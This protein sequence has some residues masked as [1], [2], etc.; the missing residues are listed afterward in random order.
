MPIKFNLNISPIQ[1]P[2]RSQAANTFINNEVSVSGF[3]RI[4][5]DST[6]VSQ[7]LN[8]VTMRVIGNMECANIFGAKIVT[9]NVICARGRDG[10]DQN[11]CLGGKHFEFY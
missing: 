7:N 2:S 9:S 4:T 8:Y 10:K 11:A 6:Q 1:L 5:D 3:G